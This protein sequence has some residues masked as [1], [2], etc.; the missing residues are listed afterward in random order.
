MT[1]IVTGCVAFI[2]THL[3][4]KLLDLNHKVI[5]IDTFKQ[6]F[7]IKIEIDNTWWYTKFVE[8]TVECEINIP[9]YI[10]SGA[11]IYSYDVYINDATALYL[12]EMDFG[13]TFST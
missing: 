1:I 9:S 11:A 13:G 8:Y 7:C 3:T 6:Q 10:D 12:I 2:G 5:G 4:K